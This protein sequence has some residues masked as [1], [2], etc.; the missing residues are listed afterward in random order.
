MWAGS[1]LTFSH[2]LHIG[3]TV[4]RTS[5]IK[6]VQYKTG[7]TGE[8]WFVAVDHELTVNGKTAVNERHDIVYRAMPDPSRPQPPRPRLEQAAQWQRTLQADPVMLFRYSALTFNGHRIHYDRQ[9]TREVEG[10][11]GLVVHGPMQAMLMLDLVAREQPQ[12]RVRRFGFRGLAPLFDQDTII[13]GGAADPAQAGRLVLW[14]GDD[15]G[16]QA[17]QG[18]A[19]VEG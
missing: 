3:D 8:L 5:T 13:V 6:D 9:Y 11:P 7:R 14:T 1:E 18:W 17:M 12:A 2:P 10:Y 15:A 19:E 4:T 16:G